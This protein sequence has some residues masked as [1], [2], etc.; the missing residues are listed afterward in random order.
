MQ[1]VDSKNR[2]HEV[3]LQNLSSQLWL[4]S[5]NLIYQEGREVMWE[6]GDKKNVSR[7]S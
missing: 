4:L 2:T 5:Q 1:Q 7:H 3:Q 6:W